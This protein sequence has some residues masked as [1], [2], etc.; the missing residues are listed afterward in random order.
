ME[1]RTA[2]VRVGFGAGKR[3]MQAETGSLY[4]FVSLSAAF[5]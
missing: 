4:A 1:Q 5:T 2:R 3:S